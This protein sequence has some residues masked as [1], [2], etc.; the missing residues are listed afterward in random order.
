MQS[1]FCFNENGSSVTY[2]RV[3]S[4]CEKYKELPRIKK[5]SMEYVAFIGIFLGKSIGEKMCFFVR[6]FT[7]LPPFQ[8]L[9]ISS[10][11][12]MTSISVRP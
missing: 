11:L 8:Q 5:W 6:I 2:T 1:V 7:I 12:S 3:C 4:A 9:E 10:R